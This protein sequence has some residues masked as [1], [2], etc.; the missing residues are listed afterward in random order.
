M[1]KVGD[2]VEPFVLIDH[3]GIKRKIS[4]GTRT[5]VAEMRRFSSCKILRDSLSIFCSSIV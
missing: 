1:I 5:Q 3:M 4:T 2:K